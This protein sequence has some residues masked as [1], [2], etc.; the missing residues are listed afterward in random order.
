MRLIE[1]EMKAAYV[2]YAMSV[3]VGRALPDVRDGL[4]PVHRRI[5]FAM[6]EMGNTSN[7]AYKKCARIVGEVLGK[8][9]PHGDM[10]VY[11]SLVRMAQ[12]FSLRYPLVQGQ[13]NFGSLDGD[14]AAAM[15]YT[16]ARLAKIADQVLEDIDK[17]TVE[18]TANFD[19]TLK[20]P[21]V[22]PSKLPNLL[23]NGSSGIAVGM[24]TNIPP[25]NIK[26]VCAATRAFIDN[27]GAGVMDLMEHIKG[28]DFPTGATISGKRG[29]FDAYKTGRGIIQVRA[30][31]HEE[32][33]K[34][35]TRFIVTQIPYQVNKSTLIEELAELVRDKVISDI[36]DLRD[37]SDRHGIR[38][39]IELKKDANA[40]IVKNLLYNH[41]KLQMS[42]S[43]NLLAL[44]NNEPKT[45]SLPELIRHY[46]D[47]RILIITRR[48]RYDLKK[49]QERNHILEGLLVALKNIDDVVALIK[50]SKDGDAA[51]Q[52]LIKRYSLDEPQA[53][54]ILDLKLQRLA[55]LEQQKIKDEER[56]LLLKITEYERILSD[57]QEIKNIIKQDLLQ[58][59]ETFG[60]ERRTV[61]EEGEEPEEFIEEDLIPNEPCI[62]TISESGYAKR[63]SPDAYRLQRRGGKGVMGA[64]MKEEDVIEHLFYAMTHEQILI[65]TSHGQVHWL[66]AYHIPEG[67]RTSRGKAL[68]NL[69]QL[70]QGE[71]V[72]AVIP[73]E[74]F[75]EKH[76]LIMA[77]K[78]DTVKKSDLVEYSRPRQGGIRAISLDEGD[79]LVTACV[80]DGTKEI[81]LGTK[82]GMAIRFREEDARSIGRTARGVRGIKLEVGDA[83]VDMIIAEDKETLLTITE[84]GYG[85]RTAFTEYRAI[86]RGGK[87]VISIQCSERNGKVV[88]LKKVSDADEL[89]VMTKLGQAI[90]MHARDISVIGRNTQGLRVMKLDEGDRVKACAKIDP[91]AAGNGN[92]DGDNAAKDGNENGSGKQSPAGE[93]GNKNPAGA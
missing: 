32:K 21:L 9:H 39:M 84:N 40:E 48:V 60:D 41:S 88:A 81:M 17:E 28:P 18:F 61:I 10:A 33:R 34:D 44:V 71:F 12:D 4:K 7:K 37:E 80:T 54:A 38:I 65:F 64:D 67:S 92:G 42:F 29:I 78:N 49:A 58:L 22:L 70:E 57:Q 66:K 53:Q 75:D 25:H 63:I 23:I 30:I 87:G 85:K 1:E 14:S 45:L 26:E 59:E 79:E 36:S 35:R 51:R 6:N 27:P 15:R 91:A 56:D 76:F 86:G 90:R 62:I 2:D 74:K 47:Y 82:D 16:E 20:E 31:I 24:A 89:I 13:G 8:Y 77:T 83:V 5:L 11:D 73:V 43:I 19:E 55:A 52:G 93:S 68:V 50:A 3:I 72:S 46:V 69:V